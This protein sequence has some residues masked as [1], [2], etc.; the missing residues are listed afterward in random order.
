MIDINE[1]N[2]LIELARLEISDNE[3]RGLQNDLE[4]ILKHVDQLSEVDTNMVEPMTGGTFNVNEY[5][6]DNFGNI[7]FDRNKMIESA[8]KRDNDM[9]EVPKIFE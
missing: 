6:K 8:P 5:R 9:F 7:N 2:H 3:K 4:N 1:I